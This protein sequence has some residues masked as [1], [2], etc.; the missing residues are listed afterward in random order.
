M[1][2]RPE[3]GHH[4]AWWRNASPPEATTTK[5]GGPPIRAARLQHDLSDDRRAVRDR[6]SISN[7][8]LKFRRLHLRVGET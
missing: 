4:R 2:Q 7:R 8:S 1:M 6:Y 3:E 5:K